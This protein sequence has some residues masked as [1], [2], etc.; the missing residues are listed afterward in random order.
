MSFITFF[1]DMP[2]PLFSINSNSIYASFTYVYCRCLL[3]FFVVVSQTSIS[4]FRYPLRL[5]VTVRFK[6]IFSKGYH[7]M[8]I[9]IMQTSLIKNFLFLYLFLYL[10]RVVFRLLFSPH[11]SRSLLSQLGIC[12][13]AICLKVVTDHIFE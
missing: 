12:K 2:D 9:Q 5:L 11:F 1:T 7:C 8:W 10:F 6:E 3:F 4:G 13:S